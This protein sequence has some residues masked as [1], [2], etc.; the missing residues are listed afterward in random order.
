MNLVPSDAEFQAPRQFAYLTLPLSVRNAVTYIHQKTAVYVNL[1]RWVAVMQQ[2]FTQHLV[3]FI[4]FIGPL[5]T[6][7]TLIYD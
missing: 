4:P 1:F 3:M 7:F 2:P 5:A 6:C